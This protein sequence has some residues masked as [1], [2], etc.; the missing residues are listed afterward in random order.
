MKNNENKSIGKIGVSKV[1]IVVNQAN[2]LFHKIELE[3][4]IGND[5]FIEFISGSES[6]SFCIAAQIKSG[7]SYVR[8]NG[9]ETFIPTDKEH[10]IYWNNLN[11]PVVG[12]VYNP[13]ND[14][15]YWVDIKEFILKNP[16][17]IENGPYNISLPIENIF[18]LDTFNSFSNHFILYNNEMNASKS[19]FDA[20]TNISNINDIESQYI[21]IKNLFTYHRNKN[22]TWFILFNYFRHCSEYNLKMNLIHIISL[23]PGH[24]DIFW[25]K[26]NIV[27]EKIRNKAFELLKKEWGETEIRQLLKYIND[28]EGIQRGCIGQSIYA[29]I[30]RLED[31]IN[32]LQK[33]SFDSNTDESSRYW[34]FIMYLNDFQFEHTIDECMVLID[35][36]LS[37]FPGTSNNEILGIIKQTIYEC[38]R[39]DIY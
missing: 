26:G 21:G 32:I 14:I 29:I 12:L 1:S 31:N 11:L 24:G 35:Q 36:Y 6:T 27:N 4:D 20:V 16:N 30:D 3:N 7:I 15:I 33:I 13:K 19:F 28:E 39:F 38:G 25:H 10:L 18:N 8:A 37:L 23:I 22:A 5:A 34:A 9:E 2:C 17:I